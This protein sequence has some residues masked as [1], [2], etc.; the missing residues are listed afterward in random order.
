MFKGIFKVEVGQFITIEKSGKVKKETYWDPLQ[1]SV[2]FNDNKNN[3]LKS[4]RNELEESI[5]L[6]L[7]GDV[8]TGIFLSV[9]LIRQ[10]MHIYRFANSKKLI[11][12]R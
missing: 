6:R 12:F 1:N 11:H 8:K 7:V 5:K 4:I 2:S 10:Q 9:G 3:F